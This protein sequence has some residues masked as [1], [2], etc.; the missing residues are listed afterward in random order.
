MFLKK[1]ELTNFRNFEKAKFDFSKLNIVSGPNG[2][3]KTNLL[4]AIY[5]LSCTKSF[6]AARNHD[7]VFW[8]K[9]FARIVVWTK[10]KEARQNLNLEF[11]IDLGPEADA[12]KVVK[13]DGRKRKLFFVIGKLKTVLF[14]PESLNII[15]GAPSFRRKF[16]DFLISQQDTKYAKYLLYLSRILKNR[17]AVLFRIS[18]QGAKREEL[19]FWTNQLVEY[20]SFIILRRGQL[21]SYF[22][23][24]LSQKYQAIAGK[25]QNLEIE[26]RNKIYQ[27]NI[28]QIKKIFLEHLKEAQ[29][30]EIIFQKTIIGPQ[31]DN[32]IF[33]IN[34]K[35]L[36]N[37]G[38][39]GEIRSAVLALKLIE[40]DF[41]T[42]K[43]SGETPLFLLDDVFSELDEKRR[44]YLA[45]MLLNGQTILTTSD[46]RTIP[47][48]SREKA[49]L[50]KL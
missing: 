43:E 3:G 28:E 48:F 13:I 26:Y 42:Q 45:K 32:L 4:E 31:R 12:P 8:G 49:K 37:F 47:S 30:R 25:N 20:G 44:E 39:R 5:L 7:L 23:R 24:A 35:N 6:R 14:S 33:K 17:N 34:N 18:Q 38:S 19:E 16:L 9:E 27:T 40:V 11:I 29:D 10:T 15:L 50:F 22:N 1:I 21:V 2:R 46:P 41:L 36:E